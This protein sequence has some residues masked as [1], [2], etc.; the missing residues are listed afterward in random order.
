MVIGAQAQLRTHWE[1]AK[2]VPPK[3]EAYRNNRLDRPGTRVVQPQ[4]KTQVLSQQKVHEPVDTEE[5]RVSASQLV[6]D[7]RFWADYAG[8]NLFAGGR[9]RR[10]GEE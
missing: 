9:Q 2:R 4:P 5:V 7:P 8:E 6:R 10:D 1:H 3:L